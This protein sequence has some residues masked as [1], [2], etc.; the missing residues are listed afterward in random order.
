MKRVLVVD[1]EPAIRALVA[2]SLDGCEVVPAQ[3]GIVALERTQSVRPDVILLDVGLPGLSGKEV[4]KR[5]RADGR[6]AGIPVI[7][8][9]GLEP[10]ADVMPDGVLRKPFTPVGLRE[11][12]GEFL[13]S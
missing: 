12:V 11:S 1:D 6:T 5:L 2:A 9:T 4:L 7:L 13:A 10:P 3:D 8:L